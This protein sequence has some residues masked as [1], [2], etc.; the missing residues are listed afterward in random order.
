MN[1]RSILLVITVGIICYLVN[2]AFLIF[3]LTSYSWADEAISGRGSW[4]LSQPLYTKVLYVFI[5]APFYEELI[6]RRIVMQFFLSR[7]ENELGLLIASLTFALHHYLLGW[8][9]LKAIDMFFVGLVFG[10][11][12]IEYRFKGSW[13]CHMANNGMAVAFMLS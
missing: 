10:I 6:H 9:W 2:Y 12:Y 13:L 3:I 7:N 4:W 1:P 11:V 8:G 5:I